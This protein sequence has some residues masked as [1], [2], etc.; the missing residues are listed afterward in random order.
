MPRPSRD[1]LSPGQDVGAIGGRPVGLDVTAAPASGHVARPYDPL[2]DLARGLSSLQPGLDAFANGLATQQL[3]RDKLAEKD[4]AVQGKADAY[5]ALA[6]DPM[7]ALKTPESLPGNVPPAYKR[8]YV[9]AYADTVGLGHASRVATAIHEDYLKLRDTP[10]QFGDGGMEGWLKKR[11]Q[12]EFAGITDPRMLAAGGHIVEAMARDLRTD[13]AARTQK[14]ADDTAR[15]NFRD[16]TATMINPDQSQDA[17]YAAIHDILLPTARGLGIQSTPEAMDAIVEHM[18]ASSTAAGGRPEMFDVLSRTSPEG[19]TPALQ[20]KG[21]EEKVQQYRA[22][23]LRQRD[24]QLEDT[25]QQRKFELL[26][27]LSDVTRSGQAFDIEKDIKPYIGN[28]FSADEAMSKVDE[29]R[30]EVEKQRQGVE[31]VK[32]ITAGQ[33]YLI[34]DEASKKAALTTLTKPVLD[35]M[36]SNPTDEKTIA[37]AM[38]LLVGIHTKTP[39]LSPVM[40]DAIAQAI[41]S[42]PAK[43]QAPSPMFQ[44]LAKGYQVLQQTA[45]HLAARY[46]DGDAR[47]VFDTYTHATVEEK[48]D[49]KVA[50][51]KAFESVTPEAKKLAG[52]RMADPAFKKALGDSLHN[53]FVHGMDWIKAKLPNLWGLNSTAVGNESSEP[54]VVEFAKQEAERLARSNPQLSPDEIVQ[55]SG[56]SAAQN[57]VWDPNLKR[58]MQVPTGRVDP[59][60]QK[61]FQNWTAQVTQDLQTRFGKDVKTFVS[62]DGNDAFTVRTLD[63]QTQQHVSMQDIDNL[64]AKKYVMSDQENSRFTAIRQG[65]KAGTYTPTPDDAS[66]LSKAKVVGAL[67][68]NEQQQLDTL[69]HEAV[70]NSLGGKLSTF[71]DSQGATTTDLTTYDR[72]GALKVKPQL[73]DKNDVAQRFMGQGNLSGALTAMGEGVALTA[74]DDPARGTGR[75]IGLGYNMDQ[76]THSLEADF[77]GAGIPVEDIAAIKDG[78]KSITIDQAMRLYSTV[79]S[80]YEGIAKSALEKDHAGEW[81]KL[82]SHQKAVLTDMAYQL[83]S[84]V[85]SFPKALAAFANGDQKA[86]NDEIKTYYNDGKGLVLAEGRTNL[87]KMMLSSPIAFRQFLGMNQKTFLSSN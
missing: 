53:Q 78:K 50:Y 86:M 37:S 36:R 32:L 10:E 82:P 56:E 87:R 41:Q 20:G 43:D 23:A 48:A 54:Y 9:E 81:D 62:Y 17:M 77:R 16:V 71:L 33:G 74:Y 3:Q 47:N 68:A 26:S 45:P 84:R 11:T 34:T 60:S 27:H 66:L 75:N 18:R 35:L 59:D 28:L 22:E 80:R 12:S 63:P 70:R 67:P 29:N 46:F 7:A 8:T 25:T 15:Q 52:E 39:E 5:T 1:Q 51:A 24:S 40:K 42:V 14:L 57:F 76:N 64:Y 30:K 85:D 38:S 13:Y 6:K 4:S 72:A 65:L 55:R 69:Q 2:E 79:Q 61:R 73:A 83:G 19:I 49:P 21:M 31:A 44:A 58:I